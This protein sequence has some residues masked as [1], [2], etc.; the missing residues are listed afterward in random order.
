[1]KLRYILLLALLGSILALFWTLFFVRWF[2]KP[3]IIVGVVQNPVAAIQSRTYAYTAAD[4][5]QWVAD[6]ITYQRETPTTIRAGYVDDWQDAMRTLTLKTGDCED[7]AILACYLIANNVY[8]GHPPDSL[9]LCVGSVYKDGAVGGHAWVCL[10]DKH[11]EA[12]TGYFLGSAKVSCN[13]WVRENY[14][15]CYKLPYS[16]LAKQGYVP[17]TPADKQSQE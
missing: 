8:R 16:W 4:Q 14:W 7:M 13:G 9:A 6:N 1:M 12:T 11:W 5:I 15:L 3:N 2:A 10:E 17:R